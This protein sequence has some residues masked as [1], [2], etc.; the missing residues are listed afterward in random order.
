MMKAIEN[1]A[2]EKNILLLYIIYLMVLAIS[3][4]AEERIA[5]TVTPPYPLRLSQIC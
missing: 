2:S 1:I 3:K 5:G 4:N